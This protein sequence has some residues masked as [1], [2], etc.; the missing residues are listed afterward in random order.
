MWRDVRILW[1]RTCNLS[2]TCHKEALI[3]TLVVRVSCSVV[4]WRHQ[5]PILTW[6][7]KKPSIPLPVTTMQA[8]LQMRRKWHLK[9]VSIMYL[10]T[11]EHLMKSEHLQKC[12]KIQKGDEVMVYTGLLIGSL[13]TWRM[14]CKNIAK[15]NWLREDFQRAV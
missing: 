1:W 6:T 14:P 12:L 7:L 5:F 8:S 9:E 10:M 15:K 11:L 2:S 13:W 4:L 3:I